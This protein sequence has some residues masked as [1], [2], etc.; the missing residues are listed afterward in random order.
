MLAVA[1]SRRIALVLVPFFFLL[2]ASYSFYGQDQY[3]VGNLLD[4]VKTC[5]AST[6]IS[7][8][9]LTVPGDEEEYV[10]ICFTAKNESLNMPESFVHH[11]HHVG[12][13]RFY[14][15]DDG[16]EPPLSTYSYPGIPREHITFVYYPK[17]QHHEH[18][19]QLFLNDE[20]HRLFGKRHRWMAHFDVDEYLE[21]V[22]R[23]ETLISILKG[24]E[25]DPRV[26]QL[27]VNWQVHNS[28]NREVRQPSIRKGYTS[29]ID[30]DPASGGA[31]SRNKHVKSIVR[32]DRFL[33]SSYGQMHPHT[34]KLREG[35]I[36]V[37]EDGR[38]FETGKEEWGMP[39]PFRWPITRNRL[40]LHHFNIKSRAEYEEKMSRSQHIE[41]GKTTWDFFEEEN[42]VPRWE[43]REMAS[44]NP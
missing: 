31:N 42:K 12:I 3:S 43:C 16:S 33:D 19:N 4:T 26:G 41:A 8:T 28:N 40:T 44:Y 20:C 17:E 29:C 25:T 6:A 38:E 22:R 36:T 32:N 21:I 15:M 13:R 37:G 24:L 2:W 10:A 27:S 34:F 18:N 35:S 9:A 30:D 23:N 39:P 11:Y 5:S 1:S 14:I 7:T